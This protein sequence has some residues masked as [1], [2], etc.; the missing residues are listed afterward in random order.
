MNPILPASVRETYARLAQSGASPV[1]MRNAAVRQTYE[2]LARTRDSI[3]NPQGAYQNSPNA[4]VS[5]TW[6]R[7]L[8]IK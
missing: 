2:T 8:G 6:Q 5:Q 3:N 7:A 4:S 1:N